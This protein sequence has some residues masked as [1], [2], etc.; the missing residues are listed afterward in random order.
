MSDLVELN[1][2]HFKP[3]AGKGFPL[4]LGEHNTTATL[5][6]AVD[7]AGDTPG[8]VERGPFSLLFRCPQEFYFEQQMVELEH[9][10]LG[11]LHLFL[12]PL[13]PDDEG[14]RYE[15]VFS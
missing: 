11:S 1:V 14:Q 15:A 2:D 5:V 7:C 4:T 3:H 8:D 9:P 10:D 6:E 12:V 13:G